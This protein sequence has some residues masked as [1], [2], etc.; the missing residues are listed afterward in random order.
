MRYVRLNIISLLFLTGCG[1][2]PTLPSHE[3]PIS[4]CNKEISQIVQKIGIP[5]S[6][7][8]RQNISIYNYERFSYSFQKGAPWCSV[9]LQQNL[10]IW[11]TL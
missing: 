1:M 11:D 8:E 7:E 2:A 4:D 5:I 10:D 6:V 3:I 9:S